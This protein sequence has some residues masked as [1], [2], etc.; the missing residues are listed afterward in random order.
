MTQHIHKQRDITFQELGALLGAY[1]LI[2]HR[3][4]EHKDADSYTVVKAESIRAA[5]KGAH[6][7][8]MNIA[9]QVHGCGTV[10]CIGG[11]MALIMGLDV[12]DATRYVDDRHS[13]ALDSLFWPGRQMASLANYNNITPDQ[14]LQAI[15]NFLQHG[16]PKWPEVLKKS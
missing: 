7:F 5:E 8:N 11:T 4:I 15:E 2:R 3:F 14:S 1:E 16:D 10:S 13:P 12:S 9:C 6:V